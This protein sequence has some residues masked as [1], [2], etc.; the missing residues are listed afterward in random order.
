M[1][2]LISKNLNII[3][4]NIQSIL[5]KIGLLEVEMQNYDILIFTETWLTSQVSDD[6]IMIT[7]F[8]CPYRKDRE[9]RQGGGVDIFILKLGWPQ[10]TDLNFCMIT[11]KH[12]VLRSSFSPISSY[13]VAYI[14]LLILDLSIGILLI[15]PL[16]T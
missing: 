11:L 5:P 14:D 7:N 1:S 15:S 12:Y 16:T 8:N 10:L 13:C 6:D 3:H 4:F 2:T 9:G